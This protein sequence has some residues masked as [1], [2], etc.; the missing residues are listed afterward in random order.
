MLWTVKRGIVIGIRVNIFCFLF[1][2][3]RILHST[4]SFPTILF[5]RE[6]LILLLGALSISP[7]AVPIVLVGIVSLLAL[8]IPSLFLFG[9]GLLIRET[10]RVVEIYFFFQSFVNSLISGSLQVKGKSLKGA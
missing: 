1:L 3:G 9:V 2:D 4:Y 5:L 6:Q 8:I 7:L 10:R